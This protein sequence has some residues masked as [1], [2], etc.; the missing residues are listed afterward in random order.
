MD[1]ITAEL[2]QYKQRLSVLS[3]HN[4]PTSR[5]RDFLSGGALNGI[6][7]VSFQFEF[8]KFG[9]LPGP[10]VAKQPTSQ[11]ISPQQNGQRHSPARSLK[12]ESKPPQANS[13]QYSQEDFAKYA[14]LFSPSL[15]GSTRTGSRASVDSVSFSVAAATSSPS[16]SSSSNTGGPNSSCGTSPEPF[17]QSPMSSKPLETLTTIGEEQAASVTAG[18]PFA[19]FSNIDIGS[20][21]FDWLV[22]QNG[23]GNFDPQLFGGYREPQENILSNPTF[24]DFFF[25]DS[26]D[27]D[28]ATPFNTAPVGEAAP[29]QNLIARIDA[30]Q[31]AIDDDAEKKPNMSCNQLW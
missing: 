30:Q 4:K 24:D 14:S 25:N 10:P 22:Q 26:L 31:N 7:D 17:T 9:S 5:E 11:P 23:G 8:P 27:T 19:Q 6:G 18:Q 3:T 15:G 28:F 29:K 20:P 16:A 2:N 1:R 13:Q 21:S 12:R